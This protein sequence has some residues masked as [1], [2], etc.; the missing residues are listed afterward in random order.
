VIFLGEIVLFMTWKWVKQYEE[1][2]LI[3]L[4]VG[5]AALVVMSYHNRRRHSPGKHR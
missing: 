1:F 4:V 2:G 5:I 3:L